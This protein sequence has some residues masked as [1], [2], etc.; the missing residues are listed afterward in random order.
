[1]PDPKRGKTMTDNENANVAETG[2]DL[3]RSIDWKQGLIIAMGIPILIVPSLFDMSFSLWGMSI[4]LWVFSVLSGFLVNI[5]L[6]E[7][8]ATFGVA[9]IG[10]SIQ[11]YFKDDEKYEGKTVNKGRMIGSYG[12]WSYFTTWVPVIPIFTLMTGDY[13]FGYFDIFAGIE[14]IYKTLFYLLIGALIYS[15]I[16]VS[17]RKGLEGGA[18]AQLILAVITIIPI[19]IIVLMTLFNG[20]FH[21]ETIVNEFTPAGWQWDGNGILIVLGCFTVAQWSAVA[22]ESAATYG[23]EYKEPGRDVPKAL[24]SCGLLCLFM[25]FVI[26]FF[27]YGTLGIEGILNAPAGGTATLIP[28]A[29]GDFGDIGGAVAVILLIAGMVMIIQTAFLGAARTIQIMAKDGNLPMIFSKT[30]SY[31]VPMNAMYFEMFIGFL[32][33]LLGVT[34]S[35]ILAISAL[36]FNICFGLCM[37]AFVRA[38]KDPRFKDVERK[39]KAPKWAYYGATFMIF[40]EFFC[41][42]PGILYYVYYYMDIGYVILG[43]G[44]NLLYIPCWFILQWWNTQSHPE[45]KAGVKFAKEENPMPKLIG[46]FGIVCAVV[47]FMTVLGEWGQPLLFGQTAIEFLDLPTDDFQKYIPVIVFA[48]TLIVAF[49]EAVNFL[50]KKASNVLVGISTVL[51]AVSVALILMF[52][53]WDVLVSTGIACSVALGATIVLLVL[54]ICQLIGINSKGKNIF[55]KTY[56]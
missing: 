16:I 31:G 46:I 2:S 29:K 24:I 4:L 39:Y 30:N 48:L 1:M 21:F 17:G 18:K 20:T 28:V 10:G 49:L 42:T 50:V 55:N 51:A 11:F 41:M 23:A 53:S 6:G 3:V 45:V 56:A 36:A 35:Q 12:A 37:F 19:L 9:G 26:S 33:I 47:A 27:M 22:W 32:L 15:F 25:Y 13:L 52:M 40:F 7:L 54:C 14:G 34:S 44:V 8:C 43:L 38:R 5:P